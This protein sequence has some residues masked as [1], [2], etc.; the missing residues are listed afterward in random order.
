VPPIVQY[1]IYLLVAAAVVVLVRSVQASIREKGEPMPPISPSPPWPLQPSL[2]GDRS[3][4]AENVLRQETRPQRRQ[5]EARR[6]L[7]HLPA[8]DPAPEF[9]LIAPLRRGQSVEE[10]HIIGASSRVRPHTGADAQV[11]GSD[12]LWD[13]VVFL[14][15]QVEQLRSERD[16]QVREIEQLRAALAEVRREKQSLRARRARAGQ[17]SAPDPIDGPEDLH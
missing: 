6:E 15:D 12:D 9:A 11:E 7:A 17:D 16:V 1:L 13:M 4:S 10:A 2:A 3:R 14:R 8:S 5:G